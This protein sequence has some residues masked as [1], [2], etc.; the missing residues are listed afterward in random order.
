MGKVFADVEI[1]FR[2]G[3]MTEL[4][5]KSF[6]SYELRS[7]YIRKAKRSWSTCKEEK[8]LLPKLSAW[9]LEFAGHKYHMEA[10]E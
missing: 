7:S 4:E 5:M 6:T 2:Q 8:Q 3:R 10:G 9:D 1:R